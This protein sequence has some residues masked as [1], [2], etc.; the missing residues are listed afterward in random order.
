M[1]AR[2]SPDDRARVEAAAGPAAEDAGQAAP[3][4]DFEAPAKAVE[5]VLGAGASD[6]MKR[7]FR[8]ALDKKNARHRDGEAHL[9]G[10]S[11]VLIREREVAAELF[12]GEKLLPRD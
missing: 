12:R 11:A 4:W 10:D 8:E 7:K 2:L 1:L 9:D 3:H 5:A 6:E